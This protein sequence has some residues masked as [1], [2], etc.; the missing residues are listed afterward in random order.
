M[1]VDDA[2]EGRPEGFRHHQRAGA[3][4]AEHEVVILGR[5]QRIGGDRHDAGLDAAKKGSGEIDAVEQAQHHPLLLPHA[6]PGQHIAEAVDALGKLTVGMAAGIVDEG[7][8]V[9]APGQQVALD[10]IRGGVVLARDA[11]PG[12]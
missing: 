3:R 4:V 5:Q 9:A 2:L 6:Q 12:W 10:Q 1:L 7:R 8:L 11:H